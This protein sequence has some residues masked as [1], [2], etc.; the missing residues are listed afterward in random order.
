MVDEGTR[1]RKPRRPVLA[2]V[3][4]G[5]REYLDALTAAGYRVASVSSVN[6][7]LGLRPRPNALIVELLVP[8]ED[9]SRLSRAMKSGRRTR[10]MT[11]VALT[12]A[13][14]QE[15]VL[16]AGAV[17]CRYPCPPDELVA[18]VKRAL[19]LPPR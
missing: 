13:E 11:V 19:P 1:A 8:E 6:E 4:G 15:S 18:V 5:K 2:L 10:A 12:S 7:A 17:F 9:L 3:D 14:G 16:E